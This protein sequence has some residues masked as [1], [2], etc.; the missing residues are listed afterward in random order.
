MLML[1]FGKCLYVRSSNI[2]ILSVNVYN[3]SVNINIF[4][5]NVYTFRWLLRN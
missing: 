5:V 3:K 1:K 4:S 2:N